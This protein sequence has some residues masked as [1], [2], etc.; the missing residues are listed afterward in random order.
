MAQIILMVQP[1][2]VFSERMAMGCATWQA[3][4]GSGQV[5]FLVAFALSAAA[6]GAATSTAVLSRAG[7]TATR[8]ACTTTSGSGFVVEC[9][10]FWIFRNPLLFVLL[11]FAKGYRGVAPV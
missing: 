5:A 3:M 4:S 2:L 11:H 8:S 10:S 6:A 1:L 9:F 7:T